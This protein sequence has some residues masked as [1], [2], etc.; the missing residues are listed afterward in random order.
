[1]SRNEV[2]DQW[3]NCQACKREEHW[4]RQFWFVVSRRKMIDCSCELK[5]TFKLKNLRLNNSNIAFSFRLFKQLLAHTIP[6]IKLVCFTQNMKNY[7]QEPR[8]DQII[9]ETLEHF[10][11]SIHLLFSFSGSSSI[12]FSST[13]LKWKVC[14]VERYARSAFSCWQSYS[15]SFARFLSVFVSLNWFAWTVARC[16]I[17]MIGQKQ[18]RGRYTRC[19]TV[20]NITRASS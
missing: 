13:M 4:T 2:D 7:W 12:L 19:S 1:M 6:V 20:L 8:K 11:F 17:E 14:W 10:R 5:N 9:Q 3:K 18:R 15:R 16:A